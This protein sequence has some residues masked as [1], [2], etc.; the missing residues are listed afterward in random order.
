MAKQHVIQYVNFYTDGSAA[1]KIEP[2]ALERKAVLPKQKK[3]KR[4][5][6]RLDPVAIFGVA[7]A[8]CMLIMMLVGISSLNSARE[9]T[10]TMSNYVDALMQENA[11]LHAQYADGYNLEEIRVTALALGMI[12]SQDAQQTAIFVA[13]VQ[14]PQEQTGNSWANLTALLA[15]IFA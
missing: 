1:R 8:V 11:T 15:D 7:V 14:Q 3:Q 4:K 10:L 2:A 6:I 13:P 12:P 5:V 9:E